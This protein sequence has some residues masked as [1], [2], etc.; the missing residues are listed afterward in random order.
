MLKE[1][2]RYLVSLKENKIYEINGDTYSDNDL[3]RI[4][5]HVDRPSQIDV[6]GLDS[7]VKL[8]RA[9]LDMEDSQ[10]IFVRICGP[11]EVNVFS[12][13]DDT[14]GRDHLYRAICDAPKWTP[15]WNDQETTIIQLRSMFIPD[16]DVDYLL[17][18][19]SSI[20]KEDGI[21]SDDNGVS[22]AVTARTGVALKQIVPVKPRVILRPFRTFMEVEQPESEFILRLNNDAQVGLLEAD[23]SAWKMRAKENIRSYF[24]SQLAEEIG[25]GKVVVMM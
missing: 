20:S 16:G 18:L 1:A 2:L 11:R 7:I 10:P 14:M 9:E 13:L 5:P 15:G 4:E 6:N 3:H 19:I 25:A 23:G 21:Q 17:D 24:E 12:C 8:V 22:Q